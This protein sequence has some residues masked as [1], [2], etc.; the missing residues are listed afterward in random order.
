[1]LFRSFKLMRRE[2]FFVD[3]EPLGGGYG[4]KLYDRVASLKL[5]YIG[6]DGKIKSFWNGKEEKGIPVAVRVVLGLYTAPRDADPTTLRESVRH[7][8]TCVPIMVSPDILEPEKQ[9]EEKK[10]EKKD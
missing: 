9:E 2:D 8:S 10:E 6:K 7:F 3:E 4:I 5:E 1:M